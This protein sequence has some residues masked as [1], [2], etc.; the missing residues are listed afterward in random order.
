M[1]PSRFRRTFQHLEAWFETTTVNRFS[2]SANIWV[3]VVFWRLNYGA[4][5]M[6]FGCIL[7]QTDRHEA[8]NA[9]QKA[10]TGGPKSTLIRRIHKFLSKVLHWSIQHISREENKITDSLMKTVGDKRIRLHIL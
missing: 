1:G 2:V 6:G 7:I 10:P 3:V 8:V 9:I 4:F 5:W